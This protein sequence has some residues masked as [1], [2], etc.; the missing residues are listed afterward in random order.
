[1]HIELRQSVGQYRT[2]QV[3]VAMVMKVLTGQHTVHIGV[4]PR[5]QQIMQTPTVLI[6]AVAGQAVIGD[7]DQ[8]P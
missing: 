6:N 3:R 7:R 4:A 1:M 8:G 5:A 2:G